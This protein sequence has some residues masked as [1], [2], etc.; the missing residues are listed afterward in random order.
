ME[1]QGEDDRQSAMDPINKI[2]MCMMPIKPIQGYKQECTQVETQE[3]VHGKSYHQEDHEQ[4][5][6]LDHQ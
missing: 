5:Q 4:H 3:G 6:A 1:S 2:L